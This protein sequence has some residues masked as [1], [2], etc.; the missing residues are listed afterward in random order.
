[1]VVHARGVVAHL[2]AVGA[3]V[4]GVLGDFHLLDAEC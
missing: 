4:S 3:S 2:A 1:M